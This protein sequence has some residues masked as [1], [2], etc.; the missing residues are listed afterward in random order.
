MVIGFTLCPF[1]FWLKFKITMF[2]L[3]Y[4]VVFQNLHPHFLI[5]IIFFEKIPHAKSKYLTV[6]KELATTLRL[7]LLLGEKTETQSTWFK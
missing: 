1:F 7:P 5:F 4:N 2:K 3:S 6:S